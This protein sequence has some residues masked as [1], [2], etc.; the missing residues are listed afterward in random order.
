MPVSA[1]TSWPELKTVWL[2]FENFLTVD[3]GKQYI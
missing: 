2:S 3:R 1:D